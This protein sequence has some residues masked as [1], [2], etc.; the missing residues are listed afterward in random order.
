MGGIPRGTGSDFLL[1]HTQIE[2]ESS[3]MEHADL[4]VLMVED[5]PASVTLLRESLEEARVMVRLE[6]AEDGVK[7]LQYLRR[8][9]PFEQAARPDLI[10]L[11]L[12]L[13]RKDGR[14]VLAEIKQDSC[15]KCIPVIILTTSQAEADIAWT[16]KLGANC[17][18]AKPV[19]FE[20]FKKVVRSIE[21]FWFTIAK[22]PPHCRN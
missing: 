10:L 16:Y 6:V 9:P 20:N 21:E 12:N 19:N 1:H 18:I 22:L 11:D 5:D 2:R 7:T 8:E 14:E 4:C 3:T 15:L 13:P 17:Y